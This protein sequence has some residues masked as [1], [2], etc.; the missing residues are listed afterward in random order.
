MTI[1]CLRKLNH[2]IFSRCCRSPEPLRELSV[3]NVRHSAGQS[4]SLF[5]VTDTRRSFDPGLCASQFLVGKVEETFRPG[6]GSGGTYRRLV[7]KGWLVTSV[8]R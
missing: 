4:T 6:M 3:Q 1:L 7:G 8:Y 2:I 5:T